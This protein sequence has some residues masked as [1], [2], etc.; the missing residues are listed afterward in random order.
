ML[1][2]DLGPLVWGDVD[3]RTQQLNKQV[4]ILATLASRINIVRQ[5]LLECLDWGWIELSHIPAHLEQE[6]IFAFDG[7]LNQLV[8]LLFLSNEFSI[9]RIRGQIHRQSNEL[10]TYDRLRTVND[11]LVY[12]RDTLS[13]SEGCFEL[14][15]LWEVI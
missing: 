2:H 5:V 7:T 15:F 6:R 10:L 8:M 3:H 12:D 4:R 14:I 9:T 13:I 11:E 1:L